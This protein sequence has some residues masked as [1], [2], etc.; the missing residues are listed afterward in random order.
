MTI[1][2]EMYEALISEYPNAGSDAEIGRITGISHTMISRLNNDKGVGLK[3]ADLLLEIN[4]KQYADLHRRVIA[5]N[6]K[7]QHKWLA[8]RS[9]TNAEKVSGIDLAGM[10]SYVRAMCG[11]IGE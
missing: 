8:T 2:K 10:S 1:Q 6:E 5:Y 11:Y 7:N 3:V 9:R 4:A